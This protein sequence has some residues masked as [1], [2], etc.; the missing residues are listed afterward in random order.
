MRHFFFNFQLVP[1][2]VSVL[3]FLALGLGELV[4]LGTAAVLLMTRR[5]RLARV[6]LGG[7]IAAGFVYLLTLFGLSAASRDQVAAFGDEKYFCEVDCHL[8]YSV[9][10][11]QSARSIG[12]GAVQSSPKGVYRIVTLRVR[13]DEETISRHRPR[14]LS[15][16]PNS[17][18][19]RI[20][21]G[22]GESYTVDPAGQRALESTA[23]AQAPLTRPLKPGE[24]YVTRLVFDLPVNAPDPRLLITESD[25]VTHLLLGHENSFLH[26]KTFF[27]VARRDR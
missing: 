24:S 22:S 9:V 1:A 8:A 7:A 20:L 12:K 23:G 18:S 11:V 4:L 13:F 19:V 5:A 14:D 6:V 3:S 2:P 10:G 25:W 16:M 15:L 26:Q 27:A 17:R 21:N